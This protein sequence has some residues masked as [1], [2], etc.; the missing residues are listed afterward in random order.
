M[1]W[2]SLTDHG[3]VSHDH[4]NLCTCF[5]LRLKENMQFD[6][7]GDSE[8]P[9]GIGKE[10]TELEAVDFDAFNSMFS[11]RKP[12][13]IGAGLSSG[14]KSLVKGILAGTVSLVGGPIIGAVSEGWVGFAKGVAVGMSTLYCPADRFIC[15]LCKV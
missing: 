15:A 6:M 3:V 4:L 13:D 7:K 8:V 11:L 14:T 1:P 12:R 5:T 10:S 2:G 9:P